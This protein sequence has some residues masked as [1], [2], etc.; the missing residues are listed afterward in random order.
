MGGLFGKL[1]AIFA[2]VGAGDGPGGQAAGAGA[3]P[4]GVALA[5]LMV[6]LAR[7]DGRFDEDE[8][9]RILSALDARFGDGAAALLAR[10]EEAEA[11]AMDHHQFTR[12]VKDAFEPEARGAVLEELWEVVLADG[13]RDDEENA[14][15]R[16]FASLLHVPDQEVALARRRVIARQSGAGGVP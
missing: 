6:R 12:L 14:L 5:A 10:A 7:A 9:A 11:N 16:Q 2:D 4:V 13:A 3:D 8:R 15:M 1:A